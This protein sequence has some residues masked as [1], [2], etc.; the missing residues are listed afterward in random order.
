MPRPAGRILFQSRADGRWQ[1]FLLDPA[2]GIRTRALRSAGDDTYP[3]FSPDGRS[4]LLE[5]TREGSPAIYIVGE[6][7]SARRLTPLGDDCHDPAW[8]HTSGYVAYDCKRRDGHEIY[9]LDLASNLETRLTR[10]V[11]R[12]VLPSWSPDGRMVAFT[13]NQLGWDVYRMNADGS[14]IR[15]ISPEGGNC[16][17][18]WSPDGRRI[19]FVS[20][21]ADGKGDIWL[22]DAD[23]RNP[24]RLTLSGETHDYDP[25]W[26]PDGA[27]IVYQS[28]RDKAGPW[29]LEAIPSAGGTPMVLSPPGVDDRFPDWAR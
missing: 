15:A 25:S 26:S 18:D 10:S 23:G 16:R 6:D 13:R 28:A 22:V 27:W 21:R 8:G 3:S 24:V 1:L 20:D 11:W 12:S 19:A 5:S 29:R 7:A 4:I 17:P 14:A 9:R 2:T